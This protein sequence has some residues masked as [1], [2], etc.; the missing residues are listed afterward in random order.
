MKRVLSIFSVILGLFT[1]N[2]SA[3]EA[4]ADFHKGEW[5]VSPFAV[6]SDQSGDKWGIG[7]AVTYYLTKNFGF[8]GAT[9]WTDFNG[10]F[11]NNLEGEAYFRITEFKR[12]NPYAVGSLGYQFDGQYL[13]GTFGAGVNFQA[14]KK[15]TVFSDLQYRVANDSND[16]VFLRLGVRFSF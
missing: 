1:L 9:Y 11:I 14:L 6:Y 2:A 12:L 4:D 5:Q 16:G 10:T 13:F 8:G 7:T 3:Q 15:L